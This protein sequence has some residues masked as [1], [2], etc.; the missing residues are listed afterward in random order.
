MG[1]L[2]RQPARRRFVLVVA[3]LLVFTGLA[4]RVTAADAGI[5]KNIIILFADGAAPVQWDF[6]RRSSELL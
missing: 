2:I 6:G 5:P 1:D 3:A 4:D